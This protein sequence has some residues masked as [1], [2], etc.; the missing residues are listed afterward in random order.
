MSRERKGREDG[1]G[2]LLLPARGT[3]PSLDVSGLFER[4]APL[5]VDLGCGKGRFLLSRARRLGEANFLGVDRNLRRLAKLNQRLLDARL[6]NVRLIHTDAMVFLEQ[7]L[8]AA[9]VAAFYIFFPDPWPKRRHH[10]RRLVSAPF[11]QSIHRALQVGGR[12]YLATD[13]REYF[14]WIRA[15]FQAQSRFEP[16]APFCHQADECT[17][18]ELKFLKTHAPICRCAFRKIA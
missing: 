5:E 7:T 10:R 4:P 2:I 16:I 6:T 14:E 9:G 17:D 3:I 13:H 12:I 15:H 8:P 18:F 11:A 1:T